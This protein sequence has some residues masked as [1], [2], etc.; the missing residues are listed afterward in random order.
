MFI[1]LPN[2]L[3]FQT[4]LLTEI[5]QWFIEQFYSYSALLIAININHS[6]TV[7]INH[8]FLIVPIFPHKVLHDYC[9]TEY[10]QPECPTVKEARFGPMALDHA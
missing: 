2:H 1:L 4:W 5:R 8:D 7:N 3:Y 6:F 9:L 10:L